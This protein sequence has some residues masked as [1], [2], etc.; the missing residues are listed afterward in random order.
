[1]VITLTR[2]CRIVPP[3]SSFIRYVFQDVVEVADEDAFE[4]DS[5]D[6]NLQVKKNKRQKGKK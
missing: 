3:N 2:D 6:E 1:M 4:E 5:E